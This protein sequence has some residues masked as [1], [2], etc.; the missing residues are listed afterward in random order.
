MKATI[1]DTQ[2]YF[3]VDGASL[4]PGRNG[5]VE[6]PTALLVHGG[7]GIDHTG[8]K[9]MCGAL[10]DTMQLVYFDQRGQGRSARG[11][12]DRYTLD[13]NVEDMEGLRRHLG[14][15][16]IVSI[17]ASYGG[18]VAMAHAARY[19]SAVSHLVLIATFAHAGYASRA[20]QIVAERG[21]PEQLTFCDALFDGTLDTPT[22]VRDFFAGMS[23][24][25]SRMA[26]PA[27][28]GRAF[29]AIIL[30][31]E[32]LNRAHGRDGFLRTFDLRPE[33]GAISAPTLI[34]AG[35]HDWISA[36]EFSEEIGRL[37][38]RSDLRI[39]ENSAHSIAS[40]EPKQF[41]DV[42]RGFVVH[43]ARPAAK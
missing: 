23:T 22:K 4:V 10:T 34:L 37:I 16:S 29:E 26:D 20:R 31:P 12:V 28:F 27:A 39:F 42:I 1:R 13:E 38:T 36:P 41:L 2:I 7:P 19:A 17:G 25:Y 6:R 40:D 33:L 5:M 18:I 9:S 24:L 15:G 3:D 8:S 21:S 43:N 14:L 30:S 35:R 11:D 32:A